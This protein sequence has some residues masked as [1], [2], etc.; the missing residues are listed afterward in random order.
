MSPQIPLPQSLLPPTNFKNH[1]L[2]WSLTFTV[3]NFYSFITNPS[4]L[5]LWFSILRLVTM[6]YCRISPPYWTWNFCCWTQ[7]SCPNEYGNN[8][9]MCAKFII[10]A[11]QN[12]LLWSCWIYYPCLADYI[13]LALLNATPMFFFVSL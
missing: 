6:S 7:N 3:L 13:Y 4:S 9:F 1:S 2:M 10:S 12:V 11:L 8:I 5:L